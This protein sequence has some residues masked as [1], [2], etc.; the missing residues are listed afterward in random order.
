MLDMFRDCIKLKFIILEYDLLNPNLFSN[1][2]LPN[3]ML[4]Q[5]LEG[6]T[7]LIAFV[8][9]HLAGKLYHMEIAVLVNS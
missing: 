7:N 4:S 9:I 8:H 3:S 5:L 2:F 6:R 1:A